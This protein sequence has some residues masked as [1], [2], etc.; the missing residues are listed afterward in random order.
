MK[1][2]DDVHASSPIYIYLVEKCFSGYFNCQLL[3][4]VKIIIQK[5][6]Y[7]DRK[8]IL[9]Q[10]RPMILLNHLSVTDQMTHENI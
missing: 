9:T 4:I 7:A 1:V 3:N 2:N 5:N 6:S 8:I 10:L